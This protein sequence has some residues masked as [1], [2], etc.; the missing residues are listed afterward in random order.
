MTQRDNILQELNELESTLANLSS[1]NIYTVPTGYFE[2]LAEQILN[3]IKALETD[4]ASDELV[5]LSSTLTNISKEIPYTTPSGYFEELNEKAMH[6]IVQGNSQTAKE[7]LETLSPLLSG[8]KKEM[9]FSVPDGYFDSLQTKQET[10]VVSITS[11]KWFR[12]AAAAMIVG[13]VAT[14]AFLLLNNKQ[15][16]EKQILAKVTREVNK[17][18]EAEKDQLVDFLDA[19]LNGNETVQVSPEK[20]NDLKDFLKGVS[21]KELNDFSEQNE[22]LEDFLLTS[23]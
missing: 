19:G 6:V 18:N 5:F 15:P 13:V 17:M 23:D 9:P 12:Y 8:L 2:G 22:D 10:K 14:T 20:T 21:E 11:R 1:H 16:S 4:N 7:E 3:R